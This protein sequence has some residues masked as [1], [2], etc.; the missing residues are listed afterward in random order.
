MAR[1]DDDEW[2]EGD[3][4]VYEKRRPRRIIKTV[5]MAVFLFTLGSVRGGGGGA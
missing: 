1:K 4:D 3:D 2:A 5:A